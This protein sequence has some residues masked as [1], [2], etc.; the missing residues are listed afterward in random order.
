MRALL[1]RLQLP[2][3]L[4]EQASEV[5][6]EHSSE[7]LFI[8]AVEP[9][10]FVIELLNPAHERRTGLRNTD[11][12]GRTP[13]ECLPPAAAD[14]VTDHY[15]SCVE[16]GHPIRYEETLDLPAG[17]IHYQTLLTPVQDDTGRIYRI[18]GSAR[19]VTLEYE[20]LRREEETQRR[21]EEARRRE[22]DTRSLMQQMI[23]ASPD[24]LYVYDLI[25]HRNVFI[26][27]R[28]RDIL[29]WSRDEIAAM[30]GEVLGRLIHPEDL[31][32]VVDHSLG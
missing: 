18:L 14:A 1:Q 8:I 21:E 12:S 29:G 32:A 28:V 15:R 7:S 24:I 27:G 11:V 25:E 31:A 6:F 26:T 19:D 2:K 22:E 4:L 30:N 23:E 13:H 20:A 10:R 17:V 16:A 9:D 3:T 5:W